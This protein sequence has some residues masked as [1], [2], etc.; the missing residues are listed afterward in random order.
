ME[1]QILDAF[2]GAEFLLQ[3][4][5]E[6]GR[7][8]ELIEVQRVKS[9]ARGIYLPAIEVHGLSARQSRLPLSNLTFT[10]STSFQRKKRP[11][12][13]LGEGVLLC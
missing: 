4:S 3:E 1:Q 13:I 5:C 6:C 2:N 7:A 10:K 11:K 9:G 8:S 12:M